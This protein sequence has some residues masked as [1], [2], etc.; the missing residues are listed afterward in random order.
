MEV[1]L[2]SV[3]YPPFICGGVG[4]FVR[5]LAIGLCKEGLRV[6]VISGY[7]VPSNV[8]SVEINE[9]KDAELNVI[10]FPYFDIQPR[11]TIFQ[12]L[13][14]KKI[15]EI[16]RNID[17][18]VIHG[19]GGSMFLALSRTNNLAP[20]VV[21]FHS[22][23]R[24][25]KMIS[26][27]SLLR[28]GGLGDFWTS[29]IGHPAWFFA[30]RKELCDSAMA[31]A[32]SK[33]LLSEFLEEMGEIYRE[34]MCEIHNGVDIETLDREYGG[35]EDDVEES[36][37]TLL[38]AG[39]LTW[40]KGALNLIKIAY[41]LQKQELDFKLIVHGNGSL[42]GSIRR[43]VQDLG[44]TNLEVK[45]FTNKVQLMRSM[46]RSKFV[47]IP[48]FYEACPMILL[49][50]MCLGKIPL[51][52]DLPYSRE[53][54][55]GGKYGI[56]ARNVTDMIKKLKYVSN[57]DLNKFG[58]QIKNFAR[59]RYDIQKVSSQYIKVYKDAIG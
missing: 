15:H 16:I 3:E 55:E 57:A 5:N 8:R 52:F 27:F 9:E 49:E 35:V 58:G 54:T 28:G 36:D 56:I 13:N 12:L 20:I 39:R 38:F 48:S 21:T 41:L 32:V 40:R 19:Q 42:L 25:E 34:R 33:N 10:R 11:N 7:P 4:T 2:L 30:F 18:D 51:M 47:V 17:P 37:N 29:V 23:P 26:A 44:L 50:S 31:V 14:L 59:T 43:G 1:V 22:S 24:V 45:G 46:K 6:T 53:F